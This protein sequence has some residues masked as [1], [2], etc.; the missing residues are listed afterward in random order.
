VIRKNRVPAAIVAAAIAVCGVSTP[1]LASSGKK[2]TKAQCES[3]VKS[4]DKKHKK[5]TKAQLS[6]GNKELKSWSCKEQL[7]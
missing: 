5:P 1:A 7:K 3:Y 4:F 2:W 6:E